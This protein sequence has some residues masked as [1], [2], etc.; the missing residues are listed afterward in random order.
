MKNILLA[1]LLL[2]ASFPSFS[3]TQIP[4]GD[5]ENWTA[6]LPCRGIDS[7]L[8]FATYDELG[9]YEALKYDKI[10]YCTPKPSATK[11]TDKHSGTYALKLSP[12][13]DG[14]EYSYSAVA[15]GNDVTFEG[16]NYVPFTGRPTKLT[17]WYKFIQGDA[18]TLD[19]VVGA[20]NINTKENIFYEEL[21]IKKGQAEYT[22][23]E[24]VL[25]YDESIKT[26]PTVL[27]FGVGLGNYSLQEANKAS[28]V[29]LDDLVFEYDVITS[30]HSY[31]AASP[32]NVYE[33]ND[34]IVFSEEVS[35]IT[36][37]DQ[38]GAQKIIQTDATKN[39]SSNTLNNGLYIITYKYRDAYFSKKIILE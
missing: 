28:A 36:V 11:T 1:S 5:F 7:L 25:H 31:T 8:N 12:Y 3:Q 29:Y 27:V 21:I 39:V 16:G 24:I 23:F 26:N 13:F 34:F 35:E 20:Y 30:T 10:T 2:A 38:V 4:N 9:Y 37:I 15:A 33:A 17:G 6:F 22:K 18:D 32:V 19:F 14:T